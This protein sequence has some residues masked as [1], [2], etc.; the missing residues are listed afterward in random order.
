MLNET[1]P[2]NDCE[3]VCRA[4]RETTRETNKMINLHSFDA[5]SHRISDLFTK[6]TFLFIN[7]NDGI[8]TYICINCR[9]SLVEFHKFRQMCVVSYYEFLKHKSFHAKSD[10]GPRTTERD[11][12]KTEDPLAIGIKSE[13]FSMDSSV[14]VKAERI[15]SEEAECGRSS[16]NECNRLQFDDEMK[17]EHCLKSEMG[18]DQ[19]ESGQFIEM[20]GS[21]K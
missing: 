11:E 9:N 2:E 21:G 19:T 17:V 16:S 13:E 15:D 8:T 12:I 7:E 18:D 3:L 1:E 4:C 14:E 6:Y 10:D 5:H 20:E